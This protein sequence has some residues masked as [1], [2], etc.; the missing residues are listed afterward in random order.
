MLGFSSTTRFPVFW[1]Q[2]SI[3]L[4]RVIGEPPAGTPGASTAPII[5]VGEIRALDETEMNLVGG[6]D[7]AVC[8]GDTDP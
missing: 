7:G 8:W 1:K 4:T 3:E 2:A 6:G 5:D